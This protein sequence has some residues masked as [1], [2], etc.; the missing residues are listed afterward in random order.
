[1]TSHLLDRNKTWVQERLSADPKWF[2]QF[3]AGQSPTALWIGCADS[4]VPPEVI[5]GSGPGELF[6]HRNIANIVHPMDL[7][8]MSVLQYAVQNLKVSDV[9]VCGHIHC[10]GV[11]AAL[12]GHDDG[13]LDHWLAP[14]F[15][16]ATEEP[17]P[18]CDAD[19]PEVLARMVGLNVQRSVERLAATRIIRAAWAQGHS[20]TIHGWVYDPGTGL[21]RDLNCTTAGPVT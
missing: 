20:I 21:L 8:I 3:A 13:L 1:M 18:H 2:D 12:D 14:V 19:R 16:L 10:G 17:G 4:R 9:I 15:E 6:V 5:S 11:A 7:S